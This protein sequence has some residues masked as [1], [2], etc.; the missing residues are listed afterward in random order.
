MPVI[1]KIQCLHDNR[2]YIGS[3]SSYKRRWKTHL[4]ELKYNK[5][6][7]KRL[8]EAW[9]QFGP[10]EFIFEV[11]ENTTL[12]NYRNREQYW[13]DFFKAADPKYG[14]NN[15]AQVTYG[16]KT[17]SYLTEDNVKEI[18]KECERSTTRARLAEKFKISK[19]TISDIA[20]GR[21]WSYLPRGK[22]RWN[23][24][25]KIPDQEIEKIRQLYGKGLSQ[26]N[27]AK[28]YGVNQST[29]NRIIKGL[30]RKEAKFYEY[31]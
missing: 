9:L 23:A 17:Y 6:Y 14:F 30:R 18:I 2:V 4:Y 1:Y 26:E 15:M 22:I 31:V 16:S 11:I 28:I 10:G 3:S 21:S 19:Q 12:E 24:I 8:Q 5:H 29:I 13:I 27:I 20:A 7:C 25:K